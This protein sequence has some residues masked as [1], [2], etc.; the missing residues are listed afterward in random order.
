MADTEI[1]IKINT[2]PTSGKDLRF[3]ASAPQWQEKDGVGRFAAGFVV[4]G[5]TLIVTF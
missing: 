2:A 4:A 5:S 1:K 3:I